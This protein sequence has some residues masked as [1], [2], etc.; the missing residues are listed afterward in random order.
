MGNPES[1]LW[2]SG[3]T[4]CAAP[5]PK[6][7]AWLSTCCRTHIR[8]RGSG[9]HPLWLVL[10]SAWWVRLGCLHPGKKKKTKNEGSCPS[11]HLSLSHGLVSKLGDRVF[12]NWRWGD[13]QAFRGG[14]CVAEP[15]GLWNEFSGSGRFLRFGDLSLAC[16]PHPCLCG[17]VPMGSD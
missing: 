10:L 14:G 4:V 1:G 6:V 16:H 15:E 5:P 2:R 17:D 9:A 12:W 8:V 7:C 11:L 3:R 13:W